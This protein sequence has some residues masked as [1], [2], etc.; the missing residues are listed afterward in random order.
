MTGTKVGPAPRGRRWKWAAAI[1][2]VLLVAVYV[3]AVHTYLGQYLENSALLGAKQVPRDDLED[4]ARTLNTISY[5]SLALITLVVGVEALMRRA[6]RTAMASA[7]IIVVA[8]GITEVLKRFVLPRPELANIYENNGHNSFPSGHTTIGMAV[9]VALLVATAYRWRGPVMLFTA[10]W[11]TS[12]GAAT[13]T[14]RWHRLSDTIGADLVVMMVA[15][16]AV[17]WLLKRGNVQTETGKSYPGRVVLV[18]ILSLG[19]AMSLAVGGILAVGSVIRWDL[20]GDL[21]AARAAGVAADLTSHLDPVF[22]WNMFL[23]AQALALGFSLL[24]AL[25]FW[26]TLHRVEAGPAKQK[27]GR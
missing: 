5:V 12:I 9:V 23:A 11:G 7:G 20:L 27:V 8:V 3:L 4:A 24:T 17:L 15:S 2:L 18:I 1:S 16:L 22:T 6:V 13:I 26:G 10:F 14:A 19:A 25:W 21:S